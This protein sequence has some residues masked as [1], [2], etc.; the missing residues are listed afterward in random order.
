[1]KCTVTQSRGC[2]AF[3][4]KA[5]CLSRSH[6]GVPLTHLVGQEDAFRVRDSARDGC[7]RSDVERQWR[8]DILGLHIEEK[9]GTVRTFQQK[10]HGSLS[11]ELEIGFWTYTLVQPMR[12]N[13][14][15]IG[16]F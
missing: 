15:P 10:K 14:L 9:Q 5:T 13:Y 12:R 4:H 2:A 7:Q 8:G 1:M 3:L 11:L 6:H 16:S